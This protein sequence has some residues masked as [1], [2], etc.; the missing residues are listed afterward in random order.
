MV[1]REL[2]PELAATID[3]QLSARARELGKADPG[4]GRVDPELARRL[5]SAVLAHPRPRYA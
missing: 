3:Q 2:S 4:A 1:G 5:G